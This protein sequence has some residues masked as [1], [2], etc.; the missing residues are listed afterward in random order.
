VA[1]VVVGVVLEQVIL[2]PVVLSTVE[3]R[4]AAADDVEIK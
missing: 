1:L 4:R 3:G 2:L